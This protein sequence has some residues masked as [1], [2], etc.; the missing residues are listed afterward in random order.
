MQ[1]LEWSR[2]ICTAAMTTTCELQL[3]FLLTW[4]AVMRHDVLLR[5]PFDRPMEYDM[6]CMPLSGLYAFCS[7]A[8]LTMELLAEGPQLRE[9]PSLLL[10]MCPFTMTCVLPRFCAVREVCMGHAAVCMENCRAMS[11]MDARPGSL[12]CS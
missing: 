9:Q 3:F 12:N 6:L 5:M 2:K 8:A 7:P 4:N 1:H 10:Q 11:V